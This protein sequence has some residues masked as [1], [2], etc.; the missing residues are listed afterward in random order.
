ME[1]VSNLTP[2]SNDHRVLPRGGDI[3]VEGG[4][5]IFQSKK[6]KGKKTVLETSRRVRGQRA[7]SS[8]VQ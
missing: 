1:S 7:W 6:K 4:V 8:E 5:S 2:S 3:Y